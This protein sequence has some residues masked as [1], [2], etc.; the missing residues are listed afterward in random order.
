MGFIVSQPNHPP[1][2]PNCEFFKVMVN[3][4]SFHKGYGIF[5]Q[6]SDACPYWRPIIAAVARCVWRDN[7]FRSE[8]CK[9]FTDWLDEIYDVKF[10]NLGL[11][12]RHE[13]GENFIFYIDEAWKKWGES[14][15]Q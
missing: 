13:I 9:P 15:C 3:G 14:K 5:I 2:P 4:A 1:I 6:L 8:E 10:S 7:T 12:D 11:E